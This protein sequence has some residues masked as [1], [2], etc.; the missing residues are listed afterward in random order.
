[1]PCSDGGYG[2]HLAVEKAVKDTENFY[3]KKVEF[4]EN[5]N[6]ELAKILCDLS[7]HLK[8]NNEV[9]FDSLTEHVPNYKN[10]YEEHLKHDR[11]T[12]LR[13]FQNNYPNISKEEIER[14]IYLGLVQPT[15]EGDMK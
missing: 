12:W 5:R 15:T 6:D 2:E 14:G 9:L 8:Q 13:D 11:E 10:W 3:V 7:K 1:M 4:L